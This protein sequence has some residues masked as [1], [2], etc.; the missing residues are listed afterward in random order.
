M[1]IGGLRYKQQ[2]FN[3]SAAG[4]SS[5]MLI[6]AITG[7]AVPTIFAL[8]SAQDAF[9]VNTLSIIVSCVLAAVYIGGLI[10]AFKTHKHLFDTKDE[11]AAAHFKPTWSL[12][13]ASLVL[14]TMLFFAAIM[15]EFL[16]ESIGPV[17]ATLGLSQTFIGAILIPII[18][19]LAEKASSIHYALRN[20]INLSIE[21]GTSSATQIALF[22]VPVLVLVSASLAGHLALIFTP[23]QLIAMLLAVMIINYLSA[24]GVCNWLEGV[25]LMAVYAIIAIAFFFV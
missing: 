1:L 20:K 21:I 24:D 11:L 10:F 12:R 16:V 9:E 3:R 13:K 5:T 4:V 17:V 25:Q 22:V 15:S 18:T 14:G 7:L 8:T 19:N 23:F 6:I 2:S